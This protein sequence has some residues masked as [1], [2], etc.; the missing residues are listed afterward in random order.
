MPF[1]MIGFSL[2]FVQQKSMGNG[3]EP[4]YLRI[5]F[6]VVLCMVTARNAAMG[7]N[8]YI[9]A[10]FDGLNP[11]TAIREIPSGKISGRG[12]LGFVIVN[13]V[14]FVI[15]AWFINRLCFYLSPLALFVILFYSYTKRF[16]A[17][18]HLVL[19]TG[20]ALAP[21]GAY[22]AIRSAFSSEILIISLLV[23]CW[24][25]GFDILYAL[26]DEEFD[27]THHLNSIPALLGRKNALL[28][29]R[30]L[31]L[32]TAS[33]VVLLGSLVLPFSLYWTGAILFMLLL[34]YQH[35][36]VSVRDISRVN[37]AFATTNGLGSVLFAV[38]VILSLIQQ[39]AP[40]SGH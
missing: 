40:T 14:L 28:V 8:R 39:Y 32:V 9:D 6:L 33:C 10:V 16:T 35:T 12:A 31:H 17:L 4:E 20:L 34:F 11:R 29:S 2:A 25:S 26:Q 5:F 19:G 23:F 15:S 36:L 7:F 30:M 21:L 22:L 1:A 38:F 18:C 13:A 3:T 24:V 37:L 27:R